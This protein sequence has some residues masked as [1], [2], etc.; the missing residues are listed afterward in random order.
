VRGHLSGTGRGAFQLH[1]VERVPVAL[2]QR[3]PP[4]AAEAQ[5][6]VALGRLR[7]P[8]E[9]PHV[10]SVRRHHHKGPDGSLEVD[11]PEGVRRRE[12]RQPVQL[13]VQNARSFPHARRWRRT[14]RTTRTG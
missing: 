4:A 11:R 3:S 1:L 8:H 6:V 7:D 5:E 14:R 13:P 9:R 12:Q 2:E 10:E